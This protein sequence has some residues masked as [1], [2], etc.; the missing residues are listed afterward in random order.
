MGVKRLSERAEVPKF[1]RLKIL[2]VKFFNSTLSMEEK[3]ECL[4]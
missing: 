1:A 2:P 4:T 3:S